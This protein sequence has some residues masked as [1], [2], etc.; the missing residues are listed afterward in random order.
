MTA[1]HTSPYTHP[2]MW[3]FTCTTELPAHVHLCGSV[4]FL[5]ALACGHL[6]AADR[7]ASAAYTCMHVCMPAHVPVHISTLAVD[8][9]AHAELNIF[10]LYKSAL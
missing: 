6:E 1:Q 10:W 4:A 3:L 5:A 7:Q 2:S 8:A 9:C